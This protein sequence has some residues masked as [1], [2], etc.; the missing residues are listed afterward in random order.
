MAALW[1]LSR[2][3]RRDRRRVLGVLA[4]YAFAAVGL[5][6]VSGAVPQNWAA[7]ATYVEESGEALAG[8]AFLVAV[9]VGVAPRL[10]L[11]AEWVLRRE[12]DAQTFDVPH[13]PLSR[14]A[15]GG[16]TRG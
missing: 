4:L 5:S 16:T 8:V 11:P 2:G 9:V 13:V 6:A 7:V 14:P 3:D 10:V 1:F 12:L 15:G